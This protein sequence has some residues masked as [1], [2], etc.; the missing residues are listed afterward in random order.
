MMDGLDE[1]LKALAMIAAC[2]MVI[3]I[4]LAFALGAWLF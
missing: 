1:A 4:L 2:I 3:L